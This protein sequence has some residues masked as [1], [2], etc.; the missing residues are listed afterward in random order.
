MFPN[1]N[2]TFSRDN[3][4]RPA[5]A[6][7]T[8][9]Y[10][11]LTSFFNEYDGCSFSS[12]LYRTVS[13]EDISLW[14]E[15]IAVAYSEYTGRITCFAYDWL[16]RAFALD[17]SRLEGVEPGILMFELGTGHALQVPCNLET[18]HEDELVHH[19][20]EALALSFF[21]RWLAAGGERPR[22]NECIGYK[23]PLFLGGDDD[24]PNLELVDLDVYW[25]IFGQA[26]A[27]VKGKP[28]GTILRTKL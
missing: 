5:G 6:E 10:P 28:S 1:F 21:D 19:S 26:L 23:K 24:L 7:T 18:F 9:D 15:R 14:D 3:C 13:A 17:W 12:G 8:T 20:E 27:A 16:G 4:D 25:H 2:K 11:K 22:S